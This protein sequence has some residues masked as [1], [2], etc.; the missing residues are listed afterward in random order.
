[1]FPLKGIPIN[2]SPGHGVPGTPS[3]GPDQNELIEQD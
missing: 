1:M 3:G 2:P